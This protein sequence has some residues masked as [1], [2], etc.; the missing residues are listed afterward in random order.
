MVTLDCLA[1]F[2]KFS[3]IFYDFVNFTTEIT[4]NYSRWLINS[5]VLYRKSKNRK[6][7]PK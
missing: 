1:I 4:G 2:A 7:P 6:I 5:L 3:E